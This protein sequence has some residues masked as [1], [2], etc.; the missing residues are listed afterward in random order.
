MV[1]HR[2]R[3]LE[4]AI[5]RD[6]TAVAPYLVYADWLNERG[7]PRGELISVMHQAATSDDGDEID[8][9]EQRGYRLVSEHAAHLLGPL[10]TSGVEPIL[11][12]GFVRHLILRARGLD[13]AQLLDVD[14]P[15]TRFLETVSLEDE[16]RQV[17]LHGHMD[18]MR[19]LDRHD[20]LLV[21]E[22]P[23]RERRILAD[24]DVLHDG[25]RFGVRAWIDGLG[26]EGVYVVRA[27]AG[28]RTWW[29]G[30]SSTVN[31]V[32]QEET[33]MYAGEAWLPRWEG[34][35]PFRLEAH[36][37][38]DRGA[39]AP[40]LE[41]WLA[42]ELALGAE[43]RKRK[44]LVR[45]CAPIEDG[46]FVVAQPPRVQ[47]PSGPPFEPASPEERRA[48]LPGVGIYDRDA[49]SLVTERGRTAVSS[50]APPKSSPGPL[51]GSAAGLV[52]MVV[53]FLPPEFE[54]REELWFADVRGS[55][56]SA[57]RHTLSSGA[58]DEG[59]E[60]FAAVSHGHG[61]GSL[62]LAIFDAR[63]A[64]VLAERDLPRG[65]AR[66]E[67]TFVGWHDGEAFALEAGT[68]SF[69]D[70]RGAVRSA[71]APRGPGVWRPSYH[72]AARRTAWM[73][74]VAHPRGEQPGRTII[75]W[76]DEDG[77]HGNVAVPDGGERVDLG[78]TAVLRDGRI[79]AIGT[80]IWL[81]DPATRRIVD[82][83]EAAAYPWPLPI[84][85]AADGTARLWSL[86]S[87]P[88]WIDLPEL[89]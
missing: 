72:P 39:D 86:G 45:P 80:R 81:L 27:R 62:R 15:A 50:L 60:R 5:A 33:L 48:V 79:V 28:A 18:L 9:L 52:A 49:G 11:R 88:W 70:E 19:L 89:G 78:P 21:D 43:A 35:I 7:D 24:V 32:V 26:A 20:V 59:G 46:P 41:R 85:Y 40:P 1:L 13:V 83:G 64:L 61:L 6:P 53:R 8:R 63:R 87:G 44:L 38:I 23:A 47:P 4:D 66:H 37:R 2:N 10:A 31:Q 36:L 69:L 82:L 51:H 58:F 54:F 56:Q 16:A 68:V 67:A 14:H 29:Y 22:P 25:G 76:C 84:T 34:T 55:S 65:D 77:A 3:E 17:S 71:L 74:C 30:S 73:I 57:G 12:L 75:G 42:G